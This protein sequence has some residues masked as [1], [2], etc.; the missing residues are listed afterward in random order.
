MAAGSAAAAAFTLSREGFQMTHFKT[1]AASLLLAGTVGLALAQP[2]SAQDKMSPAP[3][4]NDGKMTDGKMTETPTMNDG[5]AMNDA[6]MMDDT[7]K[8]ND[9]KAMDSGKAMNDAKT[10]DGA[11]MMDDP[12]M[13]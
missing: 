3:M 13:K 5:K 12:K 7:K 2:A 6:K 4:M 9:G 10:M 1:I 11:K 8:M